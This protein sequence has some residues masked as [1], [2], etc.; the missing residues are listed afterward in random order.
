MSLFRISSKKRILLSMVSAF[1]LLPT[2]CGSSGGEGTTDISLPWTKVTGTEQPTTGTEQ[3]TTEKPGRRS[4][5]PADEI[6]LVDERT[7]V[8][9]SFVDHGIFIMGNGDVYSFDFDQQSFP[10][11]DGASR[12]EKMELLKNS[13]RP[14]GTVDQELLQRLYEYGMKIDPDTKMD[15]KNE[16]CDYGENSIIFHDPVN[17][18]WITCYEQGDTTGYRKDHFARKLA[19]LWM[20]EKAEAV[21]AAAKSPDRL[22]T[23]GD[24][25][26]ESIHSGFVELDDPS[27]NLFIT[28]SEEKLRA[29]AREKGFQVDSF[30]EGMKEYRKKDACYFIQINNV[31]NTGVVYNPAGFLFGD[32]T[33]CFLGAPDNGN[34]EDGQVTH[35]CMDGYVFL[36]VIDGYELK[37]DLS[38]EFRTPDGRI[39]NVLR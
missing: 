2:G 25:P 33:F 12:Y 22:F 20:D 31:A 17:D 1:L 14:C 3:P 21:T 26:M 23:P 4:E 38:V 19:D 24:V 15:M 10:D 34:G 7:N 13:V 18:K 35:D 36:A 28:D 8:A 30:L 9:W 27:E 29:F 37:Q 5:I 39:W 6:I 32:G 11:G 16:A